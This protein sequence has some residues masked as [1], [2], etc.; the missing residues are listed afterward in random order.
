[1]RYLLLTALLLSSAA[2]ATE[3]ADTSC[4]NFMCYRPAAEVS[5]VGTDSFYGTAMAMIDGVL[6]TGPTTSVVH[7]PDTDAD[8]ITAELH[9]ADGRT[10]M[11]SASF[12]RWVEVVN[13]GRAH[14]RIVHLELLGGKL[15][16]P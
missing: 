12:A 5:Y 9:G 16:Q 8:S 1:M 6:Y 15:E 4:I 10:V 14:Y 7:D 13:R 11:L 2:Q 3:L